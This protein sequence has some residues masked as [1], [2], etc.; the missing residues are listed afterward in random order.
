MSETPVLVLKIPNP[1]FEGRNRL[2]VIQSEPITLVDSGLATR[3]AFDEIVVQLKQH[4]LSIND[5][6]RVILTH[7]HI[8]HIGN[9][10]RIQQASGAEVLIHESELDSISDVD[11]AGKRYSELVKTRLREWGTPEEE[12]PPAVTSLGLKWEIEPACATKLVDG[13]V[14]D[15]GG[16]E[17]EVIHTPGHTQGSICLKL[18]RRLMT[19]DHVL[20]DISPNIGGGDLRKKSLLRKYLASLSRMIELSD[21]IDEGL[22]GHGDPFSDLAIRS[23]DLIGH[24]E[25]R[26]DE[27]VEVL[28]RDGPQRVF[29][30][31]KRLFGEMENFHLV[32]GCAEANAHL[33]ELVEQG[34]VIANDGVFELV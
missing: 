23:R 32:L 16:E 33:E 20:P 34:R 17:L 4:G 24:H 26:L 5:I 28:Q 1:F 12:F 10:W 9:A 29:S 11:P 13:Q 15:L 19:G 8:D 14:I 6:G 3:R 27:A 30:V 25:R 2:Y 18:G 31:A 7:K 22:P 21:E